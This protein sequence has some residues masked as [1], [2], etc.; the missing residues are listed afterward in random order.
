[1]GLSQSVFTKRIRA[2]MAL[3]AGMMY[4]QMNPFGPTD[5]A[6]FEY[7]VD[8]DIY[9]WDVIKRAALENVEFFVYTRQSKEIL[10]VLPVIVEAT[11]D[12]FIHVYPMIELREHNIPVMRLHNPAKVSK[13]KRFVRIDITTV[14]REA[15]RNKYF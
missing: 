11:T 14:I 7:V 2:E 13:T 12:M 4:P 8:G 10:K 3:Q 1:M 9:D 6:I 5:P 15:Q